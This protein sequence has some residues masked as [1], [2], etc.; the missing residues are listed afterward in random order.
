[1]RMVSPRLAWCVVSASVLS[2]LFT[3]LSSRAQAQGRTIQKPLPKEKVLPKQGPSASIGSVP[4]FKIGE[5]TVVIGAGASPAGSRASGAQ[6]RPQIP[7]PVAKSGPGMSGQGRVTIKG[8]KVAVTFSD[9]I[10]ASAGQGQTPVATEGVVRGT[11]GTPLAYDLD[12]FKIKLERPS[13][14]ITPESATAAA[15]VSLSQ[16]P[17]MAPGPNNV[18]MLSSPAGD[19]APDGSLNGQDF[20]GPSSFAL[21]D[22]VYRLEIASDAAQGVHLGPAVPGPQ[23]LSKTLAG[24]ALAGFATYEGTKLFTFKGAIEAG[25]KS[26]QFDL[27]LIPQLPPMNPEPGYALTLLSGTVSYRYAKNATLVCDGSFNADVE[28]PQAIAGIDAAE[29]EL[30]N[31]TLKTDETGALF[32]LVSFPPGTQI[33]AGFDGQSPPG[34]AIL[35]IEPAPDSA[36]AYFPR[37]QAANSSYPMISAGATPSKVLPGCQEVL[38]FL[39]GVS[40]VGARTQGRLPPTDRSRAALQPKPILKNLPAGA[41]P[42]GPLGVNDDAR[43][44][45]VFGRPGLTI[46]QGQLYLK[47]PQASFP[48]APGAPSGEFKL[49]TSFWGLMTAT[50]WGLTG[51]LTSSGC[52]FIPASMPIEECSAPSGASQ[53]TWEEILREQKANPTRRPSPKPGRFRLA[54]LRILDM[55]AESLKLCMNA[56]PPNGAT[57]VYTVHFPFP[58]CVDLDFVDQSLDARGRFHAALGPLAPEAESITGPSSSKKA[59]VKIPQ[60]RILWAWR[61]PIT[62]ADKDVAITFPTEAGPAGLQIP[63]PGGPQ[64]SELWLKPLFSKNSQVKAGVRFSAD[65]SPKGEFRLTDWDRDPLLCVTYAPPGKEREMGFD[66]ALDTISL[67]ETGASFNPVTRPS[68][69]GWAGKVRFP[70]FGEQAA[71]FAVKDLVPGMPGPLSFS[72]R[73][74]GWFECSAPGGSGR[75]LTAESGTDVLEVHVSG[76]R[77]RTTGYPFVSDD[78]TYRKSPG[79]EDM[80][81]E[82]VEF[83]SFLSAQ[84]RMPPAADQRKASIDLTEILAPG[85]AEP[86]RAVHLLK[87][88]VLGKSLIDLV[89]YDREA[90]TARGFPGGCCGD[91]W[92]GTYE[93]TAGP[94]QARAVILTAPHVRFTPSAQPVTLGFA[95]SLMR[96]TPRGASG[97]GDESLIDIPGVQLKLD[98]GALRGNFIEQAEAQVK[99]D[100]EE[101]RSESPSRGRRSSSPR[102]WRRRR[103]SA[104]SGNGWPRRRYCAD[105]SAFPRCSGLANAE[106]SG[107]A[108]GW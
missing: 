47:T 55:R 41:P 24:C 64:R 9:I 107:G 16:A 106:I 29:V 81:A 73:G 102:R 91:Y 33:R 76:L 1:M 31:I 39:G 56:L 104:A 14:K 87:D 83:S 96:L 21:R 10:L 103:R 100:A 49:K 46:F 74:G 108:V 4:Q 37:W 58:M 77:Y 63:A 86:D 57:M 17:F 51:E 99:K 7:A 80:R 75:L 38:D 70:F 28:L 60:V 71:A 22:S 8:Q 92:V 54:E 48:D 44:R 19:I 94:P 27:T 43:R 68:D 6:S 72:K 2:F 82:R 90:L 93:V 18:L 23:R 84:V 36:F 12:G 78:V 15:N 97:G 20:R 5:F 66:C 89:C 52:S 42:A 105:P 95:S 53:P 11:E 35:L 62:L 3:D 88:A 26:A 59:T 85:P 45:N 30:R 69:F 67:A 13:I 50:P 61:L 34:Q 40:A 32:N 79:N 25:G 101:R 65:L 98:N